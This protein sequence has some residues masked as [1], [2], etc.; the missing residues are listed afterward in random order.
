MGSTESQPGKRRNVSE[1][2]GKLA[3]H[4][5]EIFGKGLDAAQVALIIDE[6]PET[7][8]QYLRRHPKRRDEY[9]IAKGPSGKRGRS[10]TRSRD[11][12]QSSRKRSAVIKTLTSPLVKEAQREATLV[13]VQL[14]EKRY[15]SW[16][17]LFVRIA[18][19]K[20]D[21]SFA[22]ELM[23][24][25]ERVQD[26]LA[27]GIPL[28]SSIEQ[29]MENI[30]KWQMRAATER[31]LNANC[32]TRW[33]ESYGFKN[34][35]IDF[36]QTMKERYAYEGH[37]LFNVAEVARYLEDRNIPVP[38]L[39]ITTGQFTPE[40]EPIWHAYS[41][42]ELAKLT[43]DERAKLIKIQFVPNPQHAWVGVEDD[44]K[45]D[46]LDRKTPHRHLLA[47][48]HQHQG[49]YSYGVRDFI[50]KLRG[51][52]IPDICAIEVVKMFTG[53]PR[54]WSLREA[55]ALVQIMHNRQIDD[56][57]IEMIRKF[58]K[59]KGIQR[60]VRRLGVQT[61]KYNRHESFN[62]KVRRFFKENF[63]RLRAAS[64]ELH[65]ADWLASC[66]KVKVECLN[67]AVIWKGKEI[68]E[69]DVIAAFPRESVPT[70][71]EVFSRPATRE[72]FSSIVFDIKDKLRVFAEVSIKRKIILEK[73]QLSEMNLLFVF[74]ASLKRFRGRIERTI[75]RSMLG[76]GIKFNVGLHFME[77]PTLV[78]ATEDVDLKV[79]FN[80]EDGK[81]IDEFIEYGIRT[82]RPLNEEYT[83][84]QEGKIRRNIRGLV[85]K[86]T[87]WQRK[88][89]IKIAVRF[90]LNEEDAQM[91]AGIFNYE[92]VQV[93]AMVKICGGEAQ[94][95]QK[96]RESL[97]QVNR[98]PAFLSFPLA[99]VAVTEI[100]GQS[101]MLLVAAGLIVWLIGNCLRDSWVENNF[102]SAIA[103]GNVHVIEDPFTSEDIETDLQFIREAYSGQ[104]FD[105]TNFNPQRMKIHLDK[106]PGT[107]R[108]QNLFSSFEIGI[109]PQSF[110][111]VEDG[112]GGSG[113]YISINEL[114]CGSVADFNANDRMMS[115]VVIGFVGKHQR[116]HRS[117]IRS[118]RRGMGIPV[119]MTPGCF[120][121]A[122]RSS[123]RTLSPMKGSPS[124][125]ITY[126]PGWWSMSHL[127]FLEIQASS[128]LILLSFHGDDRS[129][130]EY[131]ILILS[132]G[133]II[134]DAS[135]SKNKG[136]YHE[137]Q[138]GI[139]GEEQPLNA[140]P[141]FAWS[142]D[143]PWE[144]VGI[145]FIILLF[146]LLMKKDSRRTVLFN[147]AYKHRNKNLN[148]YDFSSAGSPNKKVL[149]QRQE[150]LT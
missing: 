97:S 38:M 48:L 15:L 47:L 112:I 117:V 103:K 142:L 28:T 130:L 5:V 6:D 33:F 37:V 17:W 74:D 36:P 39:V 132:L 143:M 105:V 18:E 61:L 31:N 88:F 101:W 12:Q 137:S 58:Q 83:L 148:G 126:L 102:S 44:R 127:K 24:L 7:L 85:R 136:T 121:W 107:H 79:R 118:S 91:V 73:Y 43:A 77:Y 25:E 21:Q 1:I 63:T 111:E 96:I 53:S 22:S 125:R 57:I 139:R 35:R 8:T 150:R 116:F 34:K 87:N 149:Q 82:P 141:L 49:F 20:S 109:K 13:A 110:S 50:L 65:V 94:V 114:F 32:V 56:R 95:R 84:Q 144:W 90:G 9:T 98:H 113:I 147:F 69:F 89:E 133:L 123:S 140:V 146:I 76:S 29:F 3:A 120:S 100:F 70:V 60:L 68:A 19:A 26:Q 64:L 93:K 10:S 138:V 67:E 66:L 59:T 55:A 11:S 51:L 106:I 27:R 78:V 40:R 119:V 41:K 81:W 30:N 46:P 92:K 122:W 108:H 128:L 134:T 80:E 4:R 131:F 72:T 86:I 145:L 104:K 42:E 124:E 99:L 52:G 75:E 115:N 23:D 129:G 16:Y 45:G 71:I 2:P 14:R 135:N 54:P 62:K